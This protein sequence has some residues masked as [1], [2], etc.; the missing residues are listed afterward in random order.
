MNRASI[1]TSLTLNVLQ[2]RTLNEILPFTPY[3]MQYDK[4]VLHWSCLRAAP[5]YITYTL[6]VQKERSI[7]TR[8]SCTR[9]ISTSMVS[10]S[11]DVNL[12]NYS[13]F[14]KLSEGTKASSLF[15]YYKDLFHST[16]D[17]EK[18][19]TRWTCPGFSCF[20][21]LVS[22]QAGYDVIKLIP[23]VCITLLQKNCIPLMKMLI[24]QDS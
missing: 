12:N 4:N 10:T 8:P 11:C 17:K 5:P 9:R 16:C 6:C 3:L 1:W 19:V 13:V 7:I 14:Y 23:F 24:C 15:I 18:I 21:S 20:C 22:P 2:V